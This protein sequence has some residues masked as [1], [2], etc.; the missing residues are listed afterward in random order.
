[1]VRATCASTYSTTAPEVAASIAP[2]GTAASKFRTAREILGEVSDRAGA[3]AGMAD[4]WDGPTARRKGERLTR[5]GPLLPPGKPP[6]EFR[7]ATRAARARPARQS[8]PAHLSGCSSRCRVPSRCRRSSEA[9]ASA[10]LAGALAAHEMAAA[11]TGSVR[12]SRRAGR[13][14][15]DRGQAGRVNPMHRGLGSKAACA[16]SRQQRQRLRTRLN[17]SMAVASLAWRR[18]LV[19]CAMLRLAP[20]MANEWVPGGVELLVRT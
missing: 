9:P 14:G 8:T 1:M 3:R 12:A 6:R 2:R 16:P 7:I 20:W 17:S 15:G 11:R 4:G 18:A 5:S 10:A 13:M 19:V